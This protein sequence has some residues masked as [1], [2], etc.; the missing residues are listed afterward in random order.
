MEYNHENAS[1]GEGDGSPDQDGNSAGPV[2]FFGTVAWANDKNNII[3]KAYRNGA[4]IAFLASPSVLATFG[5]D[6]WRVY[7]D[8]L[9]YYALDDAPLVSMWLWME[10]Q[11]DPVLANIVIDL[12]DIWSFMKFFM[13]DGYFADL[14][15]DA[16]EGQKIRQCE[17]FELV[18]LRN[19]QIV[20]AEDLPADWTNLPDYQPYDV[21]K[22]GQEVAVFRWMLSEVTS[23]RTTFIKYCYPMVEKTFHE[24]ATALHTY[25]NPA[26][27][28][29]PTGGSDQY[30]DIPAIVPIEPAPFSDRPQQN[31]SETA[32][33]GIV[34]DPSDGTSQ[35]FR[36]NERPKKSKKRDEQGMRYREIPG[37]SRK[38]VKFFLRMVM[39]GSLVK[40]QNIAE[41]DFDGIFSKIRNAAEK[42]SHGRVTHEI[43]IHGDRE[44]GFL[45]SNGD[46]EA[47]EEKVIL[48][49][50][51]TVQGARL[52]NKNELTTGS[53]SSGSA[54][55]STTGSTGR[56][57]KSVPR[58]QYAM[59][60]S[61]VLL[62]TGMDSYV[63][64]FL[65]AGAM[66]GSVTRKANPLQPRLK[67]KGSAAVDQAAFKACLDTRKTIEFG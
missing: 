53:L 65:F 46:P 36:S 18:A 11:Y 26:P 22:E 20:R 50:N 51:V 10:S 35:P 31:P 64:A 2:E 39:A 27:V 25:L 28:L 16:V 61:I 19:G 67:V 45:L 23:F 48:T 49:L 40:E 41:E 62:F 43:L 56:R 30:I 37:N 13:E 6:Y 38:P 12:D 5:E 63:T 15:M 29:I 52:Y 8:W 7:F 4:P 34:P 57:A 1:L 59:L 66:Q 55:T 33:L 32:V 42:V 9:W 14:R 60:G 58:C 3:I 54:H 47:S 44:M 17:L 21:I 24:F